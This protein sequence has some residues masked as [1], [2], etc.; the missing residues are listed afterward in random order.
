MPATVSNFELDRFEVTVGRFRRFVSAYESFHPAPDQGAHPR[1]P[2]SGWQSTWNQDLPASEASFRSK[3]LCSQ[4]TT[5]TEMP[6]SN[7][8]KPVNCVTWFEANLFCIW[9]GGRLPTDAEWSYAA[10]GGDDRPY[11]WGSGIDHSRAVYG[12]GTAEVDTECGNSSPVAPVGSRSPRGNGAW[13]HSD[14]AGNVWEWILDG[15]LIQWTLDFPTPCVDCAGLATATRRARGAA[16]WGGQ[17]SLNL[18]NSYASNPPNYR[19]DLGFRCARS[20]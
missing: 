20:P 15:D 2:N 8:E 3:L 6:G 12:C 17:F 4:Y 18:V 11:P 5:W 14:L 1:I 16:F 10:G 7:E 13:G 19:A 9:D